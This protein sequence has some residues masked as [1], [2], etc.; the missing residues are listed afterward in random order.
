MVADLWVY[1]VKKW[2]AAQAAMTRSWGL[3]TGPSGVVQFV[4]RS[5]RC[6]NE[7][8]FFFCF[9]FRGKD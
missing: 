4:A 1:K 7:I 3:T 8:R 2:L 5:S 9:S 6:L